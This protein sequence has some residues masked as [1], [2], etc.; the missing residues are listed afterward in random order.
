MTDQPL[1]AT[2]LVWPQA[3]PTPLPRFLLLALLLHVW[4][5]LM[6]G[7]A[8]GGTART[9]Q[10]VFGRL[11]I[12]LQGAPEG[13]PGMPVPPQLPPTPT[14]APGE[15]DAQ[16]F[17]GALR[18]ALPQEALPPG[19]AQLGDWAPLR[20]DTP[21]AE[22]ATAAP[23][24]VPSVAPDLP[25]PPP[26]KPPPQPV[27]TAPTTFGATAVL[28]L[29]RSLVPLAASESALP[30]VAPA[31]VA[32]LPA[33]PA[34]QAGALAAPLK[35]LSAAPLVQAPQ[36]ALRATPAAAAT[37]SAAL[38]A[39]PLPSAPLA[40]ASAERHLTSRLPTDRAT[41]STALS[42]A[43]RAAAAPQLGAVPVPAT[44]AVLAPAA[45]MPSLPPASLA[46]PSAPLAQLPVPEPAISQLPRAAPAALASGPQPA[47]PSTPS[48]TAAVSAAA[49]LQ[50][51]PKPGPALP[52]AATAAGQG[53]PDAG[54]RVGTDVATLPSTPASAPKRLNLE[55]PRLR[56]GEL[57]RYST[58]G[59]LPA[60]PRP[61]EVPD[62]LGSAIEK[63][64]K[65]DCRKAYAGAGLLA[66]V[67]LAVDALREGGCKW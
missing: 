52:A 18:S 36:A 8:P 65:E 19:A 11:N 61:P 41:A 34:P 44:T 45:Q 55:L 29:Q 60:L 12:T 58:T 1:N 39:V 35:Q 37:E 5:V 59:L 14:G 53:A 31:T 21:N 54:S 13:P 50:S 6:L 67:P 57:S 32:V 66:V 20:G 7:N 62:K 33:V 46:T 4:L 56:G 40:A 26:L 17:G 47:L 10:G 28:G 64:A 51:P 63:T 49:P 25:A 9:G 22:P 30:R 24:P 3:L 23:E 42:E 38:T 16:R 2:A 15:A 27:A 48:A 43:G